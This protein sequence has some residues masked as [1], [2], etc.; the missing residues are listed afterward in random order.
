[1]IDKA[2]DTEV[3]IAYDILVGI[4]NLSDLQSRLRLLERA[5]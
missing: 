5:P 3:V 2:G 1:M 4:E